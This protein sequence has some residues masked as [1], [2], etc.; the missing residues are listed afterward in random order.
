MRL[1]NTNKSQRGMNY[2]EQVIQNTTVNYH[3]SRDS[4][5]LALQKATGL[6]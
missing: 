1:C 6:R 5:L 4:K 2:E 3:T